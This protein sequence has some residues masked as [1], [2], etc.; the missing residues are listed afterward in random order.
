MRLAVLSISHKNAPVELRERLAVGPDDL[1]AFLR[2]VVAEVDVAEAMLISTC[3][4][5]ELY[6]VPANRG[7][8][9]N[10]LAALFAV[11]R[12]VQWQLIEKHAVFREGASAVHHLLRVT[13]SLDSM[14]VGE[15]QILGQVKEAASA[16][17]HAGALGPILDKLVGNAFR[18]AKSVRTDTAIA[19]NRVSVG[20][21]AVALA[22][23]IFDDLT[24]CNVLLIGAG[25]MGETM[26]RHL[27]EGGPRRVYVC[28]RSPERAFKLARRHDW[29]ARQFDELDELL[30]GADVVLTSTGASEP[31]LTKKRMQQVIKARKY[32]PIF[33]VD[34]AVPRDVD[35]AVGLLDTVY[36]YNVDDLQQVAHDNL[37]GRQREAEAAELI[38]SRELSETEAWFRQLQVAPTITAV[39]ERVQ[40]LG[41][42]ELERTISKR[43]SHLSTADRKA[44]EVMMRATMNKLLHPTMV[45]LKSAA[46][47]DGGNEG[48]V[49][50]TQ[51]LFGVDPEDAA[52][53]ETDGTSEADPNQVSHVA[54]IQMEEPADGTQ[55]HESVAQS[56]T[57][58][59]KKLEVQ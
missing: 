22:G 45:A 2:G 56:A 16:A 29:R 36:L 30:A 17:R 13:A 28:N 58:P 33:I 20:S 1:G 48:L 41:K 8:P 4:R 43:L 51:L 24:Q 14:V 26:A 37:A 12:G 44:L 3:N 55:D 49:A 25:K 54:R 38:V 47:A 50:A 53:D 27:A 34:I 59:H 21:I 19:S 31:I 15:P 32:K 23:R 10:E 18:V 6:V 46:A 5:V 40:A 35:P 7:I 39:R 9:T 42:L 57:H 52:A 11:H